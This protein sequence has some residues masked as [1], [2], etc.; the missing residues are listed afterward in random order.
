VSRSCWTTRAEAAGH[1]DQTDAMNAY[2][3]THSY[4]EADALAAAAGYDVSPEEAE[5]EGGAWWLWEVWGDICLLDGG[6]AGPHEFVRTRDV[7]L[8]FAPADGEHAP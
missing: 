4:E 5:R 2:L 3:E 8:E 7:I 1:E 6:H